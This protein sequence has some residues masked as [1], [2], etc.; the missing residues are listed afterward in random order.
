MGTSTRIRRQDSDAAIA[1]ALEVRPATVVRIRH[2]YVTGGLTAA[3]ERRH[4]QRE[5]PASSMG[6]RKPG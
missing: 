1:G 4:P 3:L 2:Q 6:S 5:Y